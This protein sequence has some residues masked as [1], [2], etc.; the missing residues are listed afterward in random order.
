MKLHFFLALDPFLIQLKKAVSSVI[1]RGESLY[2][3]HSGSALNNQRGREPF[4]RSVCCF[5]LT[6][7]AVGCPAAL[8][9]FP[10]ASVFIE[11]SALLASCRQEYRSYQINIFRFASPLELMRPPKA[12][13]SLEPFPPISGTWCWAGQSSAAPGPTQL[14]CLIG[15]VPLG[16]FR[17]SALLACKKDDLV[18]RI[19]R[20]SER[21]K[22]RF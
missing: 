10:K 14:C 3:Q 11:T 16:N 18:L 22:E 13:A 7:V 20:K 8:P 17:F 21:W 4:S 5:V 6:K 1:L 19:K 2:V 9:S 12:R 15:A